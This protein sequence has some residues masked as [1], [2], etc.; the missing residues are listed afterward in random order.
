MTEIIHQTLLLIPLIISYLNF[1]EEWKEVR[2]KFG[3][4]GM[5]ER[6]EEQ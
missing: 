1:A 4:K 3:V 5:N 2:K 6:E